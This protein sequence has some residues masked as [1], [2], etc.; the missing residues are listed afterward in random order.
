MNIPPMKLF[1]IPLAYTLVYWNDLHV[2][3]IMEPIKSLFIKKFGYVLK[4]E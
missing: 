1:T 2:I 4:C 3:I